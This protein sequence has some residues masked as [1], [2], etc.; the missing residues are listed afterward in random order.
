MPGAN[1]S[2]GFL[3]LGGVAQVSQSNTANF[4]IG[5][6]G[7]Y[8]NIGAT[9]AITGTFGSTPGIQAVVARVANFEVLVAPSSGKQIIFREVRLAV[10]EPLVITT[11]LG[12]VTCVVNPDGDVQVT[13][14]GGDVQEETP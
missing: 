10:D 7:Y 4:L 12:S 14:D 2:N 8:D 3:T 9:G 6:S 5:Q 1:Q 11:S 13:A